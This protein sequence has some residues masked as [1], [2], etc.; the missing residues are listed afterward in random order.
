MLQKSS[1]VNAWGQ[2]QHLACSIY[3]KESKYV[4]GTLQ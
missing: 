1:L 3:T 4:S 2:G